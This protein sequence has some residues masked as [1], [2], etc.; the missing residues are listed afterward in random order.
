[1]ILPQVQVTLSCN[2]NC[3]Y[4]FQDHSSPFIMEE[5]TVD[6]IITKCSDYI[7]DECLF[8]RK[9]EM[10]WHGGEPLLAGIDFYRKVIDLQL[11]HCDIR[12]INKIQTNGTLMTEPFAEFFNDFNFHVGF[13][14]D[15]PEELH[16][17]NRIMDPEGAGSF[18]SAIRGIENFRKYG[19]HP[20]VSVLAV[21]TRQT[22][23]TG[24]KKFYDFFR[25]LGAEVQL[26]PYDVT[27]NPSSI[28]DI[29]WQ[30]AEFMPSPEAYCKFLVELFDLWFYDKPGNIQFKEL[31]HAVKLALCPDIK[32][33]SIKDKK[34]CSEFRT[35]FDPY[36]RVYSCDMYINNEKTSLGNIN[37]DSI[38]LIIARK[39][40]VWERIKDI[41]RSDDKIFNCHS[42]SYGDRCSGG[43]LTCMKYNAALS[44]GYTLENMPEVMCEDYFSKTFPNNGASFYC[45]AYR[46]C[47]IHIEQAVYQEMLNREK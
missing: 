16:N 36:G 30:A 40:H 18:E 17:R 6:S 10:I 29:A 31:K 34:R 38:S 37:E 20:L 32:V 5:K 47:G 28:G 11:N 12:F 35:I 22:I 39:Q 46:K 23:E 43:C 8:P 41:F 33:T 9:L 7:R 25:E 15:G 24:A 45:E 42:C 13:S 27:C 2:L 4:C 14:I 44:M 26:D 3:R 1:M 19:E 21:I